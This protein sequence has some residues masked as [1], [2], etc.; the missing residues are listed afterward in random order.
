MLLSHTPE[1]DLSVCCLY[2][3][4][5]VSPLLVL[6]ESKSDYCFD[7]V[8]LWLTFKVISSTLIALK[9]RENIGC[10][11]DPRRLGDIR[12]MSSRQK[13]QEE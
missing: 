6:K 7:R 5:G 13:V 8:E 9:S 3:S 11:Q 2:C 10:K 4:I 12:S 1:Q